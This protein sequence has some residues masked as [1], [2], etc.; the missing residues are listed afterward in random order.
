[1]EVG[2]SCWCFLIIHI[3]LSLVGILLF[4]IP[5]ERGVPLQ[6]DGGV[7]EFVDFDAHLGEG[8]PAGDAPGEAG[9]GDA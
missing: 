9:E 1:M 3:V 4:E 7:V 5:C 8:R 6:L 2:C